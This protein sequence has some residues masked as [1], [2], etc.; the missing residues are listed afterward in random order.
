MERGDLAFGDTKKE[1]KMRRSRRHAVADQT[2]LWES[3][4]VPYEIEDSCKYLLILNKVIS[5]TFIFIGF[6]DQSAERGNYIHKTI[7][8]RSKCTL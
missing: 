8:R 5:L 7:C 2:L 1:G 3:G 6:I 4:V